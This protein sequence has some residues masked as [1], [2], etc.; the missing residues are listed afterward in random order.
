MDLHEFL[1][2]SRALIG[3]YF[4]HCSLLIIV[5]IFLLH[6]RERRVNGEEKY[7][8]RTNCDGAS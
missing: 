8:R 5:N 4:L 6:C 1:I 7:D 3:Q 2:T